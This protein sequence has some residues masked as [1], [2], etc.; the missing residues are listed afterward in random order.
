MTSR[1]VK[2]LSYLTVPYTPDK[3]NIYK[4]LTN[5]YSLLYNILLACCY[6]SWCGSFETGLPWSVCHASTS[7]RHGILL[8][9][10]S[11]MHFVVGL[12][13]FQRLEVGTVPWLTDKLW[14]IHHVRGRGEGERLYLIISFKKSVFIII[15]PF[16]P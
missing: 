10:A 4:P 15:W 8:Q 3:Y 13:Q 6:M 14:F 1:I 9:P 16:Y 11:H 7:W 12:G 5:I 2:W